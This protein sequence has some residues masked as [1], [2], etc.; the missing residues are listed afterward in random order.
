ML[1]SQ[2]YIPKENENLEE[3]WQSMF[4]LDRDYNKS[5]ESSFA[6]FKNSYLQEQVQPISNSSPKKTV[7]QPFIQQEVQ[8]QASKPTK[9]IPDKPKGVNSFQ[10]NI[11]IA[12][13][14]DLLKKNVFLTL[15]ISLF[16]FLIIG[17]LTMELIAPDNLKPSKILGITR[18]QDSESQGTRLTQEKPSDYQECLDQGGA[19]QESYPEQ[20]QFEGETFT[21]QVTEEVSQPT[22]E[23][24]ED[25]VMTYREGKLSPFENCN[26]EIGYENC[27]WYLIEESDLTTLPESLIDNE[28]LI[29]TGRLNEQ[30]LKV[31][32]IESLTKESAATTKEPETVLDN[33]EAEKANENEEEETNSDDLDN[34]ES[35]QESVQN[36]VSEFEI[37]REEAITLVKNRGEVQTWLAKFDDPQ[38]AETNKPVFQATQVDNYNNTWGVHVYEETQQKTVTFNYYI[39][40]FYSGEVV[41]VF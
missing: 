16:V 26:Q 4:E 18:S 21:R 30:D 14:L 37:R 5:K 12:N 19:I 9:P 22:G 29:F 31:I 17:G 33:L 40:Y 6:A 20:C 3:P 39:V 7:A 11:I 28:S 24:Y 38:I 1:K 36:E 34:G 2:D 15:I 35:N 41:R 23:R 32:E 25:L 8:T 10:N 13:I 27:R